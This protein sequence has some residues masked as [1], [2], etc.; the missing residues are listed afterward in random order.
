MREAPFRVSS[1]RAPLLVPCALSLFRTKDGQLNIILKKS[2]SGCTSVRSC[3][4]HP[5]E[6]ERGFINPNSTQRDS[7]PWSLDS[8]G[9][10]C[11]SVILDLSLNV[12]VLFR[13]RFPDVRVD[14][15]R[16][17]GVRATPSQQRSVVSRRRS[18]GPGRRAGG[19]HRRLADRHQRL[20]LRP[21]LQDRP[22]GW[23]HGRQVQADQ[24]DPDLQTRS[25]W[26]G[27]M[28]KS[29]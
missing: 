24:S 27:M 23:L 5:W 12:F 4:K 7:N 15:S 6:L 16:R 14:Q 28:N 3:L 26:P 18:P 21:L 22:R 2:Q 25:D 13:V 19:L 1:N 17:A 29:I 20:P 11:C 9:C 8:L 10:N